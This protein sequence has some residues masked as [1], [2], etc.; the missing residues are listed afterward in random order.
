MIAAAG[1]V[2]VWL[3]P[4]PPDAAAVESGR[5]RLAVLP[6]ANLTGD[7]DRQYVAEGLTEELVAQLGRLA[8]TRLGVI[9]RSSTTWPDGARPPLREIARVLQVD[10]V[11]EGSVRSVD[12]RYRIAVRLI[13]TKALSTV[14]SEL[15]EGPIL[16]LVAVERRVS[17]HVGRHLALA[18]TPG[19]P[20]VLARATT[21]SSP[22]FDAYLRGL[23]Q[24]AR[25]PEEGFRESV[26]LFQRAIDHD[27]A[28][29]LAY[30]ALS[31]AHLRL[32]DYGLVDPPQALAAARA[33]ALKALELDERLAEAHCALGD[34]LSATRDM[35]GAERAFLR[36]LALNPSHAAAY[37]R[38]AWHLTRVG[39]GG[40][41]RALIER[42]R[43]L[44]PRSADVATTAAYFD[45]ASGRLESAAA[46]SRAAL[47]YESDYPFARYVLGQ[48]ALR[49]GTPA[50]A[51]D[52]FSRARF[53]SRDAPKYIAAL[54]GA[55]LTAG[56]IED[57]RRT[58]G[59]L[60][61]LGRKRY[62]P[63]EMIEQ[64]DARVAARAS[65]GS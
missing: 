12:D 17:L 6:F 37:E 29:A 28:Y 15:Y 14:W 31:E 49:R 11:I 26:R 18:L 35:S 21:S 33:A 48:I 22:A 59:E 40:E 19:D 54:A 10:Y 42:A 8:P 64:L 46:L 25:G 41:S 30:A 5:V 1:A 7:P 63:P 51:I 61:L 57:A 34:V 13:E 60:R 4:S 43:A 56:R 23:S 32:Q 36:A 47:S 50:V 16:D 62:V 27:P 38:Y 9:A 3:R 20:T 24:L 55:Y 39:R 65:L 45:F 52:E 58:L 44:A 53:A 2:I